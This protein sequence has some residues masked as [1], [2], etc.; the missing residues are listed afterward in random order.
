[1]FGFHAHDHL[2]SLHFPNEE[3]GESFYG[4]QNECSPGEKFQEDGINTWEM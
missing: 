1:M 4:L 3:E 2:L